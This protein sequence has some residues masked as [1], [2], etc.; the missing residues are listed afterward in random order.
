M[1]NVSPYGVSASGEL[2]AWIHVRVLRNPPSPVY[3]AY[4]TN[5][6]E[7][8]RLRKAFEERFGLRVT[9][10]RTQIKEAS[11]FARY[12]TDLGNPTEVI[13]DTYPLAM[14]RLAV[15]RTKLADES[16]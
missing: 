10:G 4:S 11:W 6:D 15:L 2:D 5:P 7:A 1:E 13:A 3:P 16:R 8:T 14:C 9:I 12:E